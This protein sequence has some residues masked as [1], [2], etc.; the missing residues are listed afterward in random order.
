[1]IARVIVDIRNSEVDKIFDYIV[2]DG[3]NLHAGDRVRVPFGKRDTEGFCIA[4]SEGS[5]VSSSRL[6]PIKER[7]D[8]FTCVNP[9]MLAL[10]EFMRRKFYLRYAD[11]LRLFVPPQMR[12][13]KVGELKRL[14]VELVDGADAKI[15]DIPAR[16]KRRLELVERLKKGGEYLSVLAEEY[17][18]A[19]INALVEAGIAVKTDRSVYRKPYA[20]METSAKKVSRG[21]STGRQKARAKI[22]VVRRHAHLKTARA[23]CTR[24]CRKM[25]Y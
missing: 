16:A 2:P 17:G 6:K 21:F 11:C 9:D 10:M 22:H 3:M 23:D 25:R 12:G 24:L 5:E 8:A 15:A 14:Y 13:G 1:M 18:A 20:D 7:L 4:L 19:T